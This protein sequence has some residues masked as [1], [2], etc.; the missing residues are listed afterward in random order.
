MSNERLAVLLSRQLAGE[1]SA[2]EQQELQYLLQ[3]DPGEQY[4][5]ELLLAYWNTHPG[6]PA[7][8][9][10]FR[11]QHF[12]HILDLAK[13][14]GAA[15][16]LR[17]DP[18]TPKRG[19][20]LRFRKLAV[21]ALVTGITAGGIGWYFSVKPGKEAAAAIKQNEIAAEK[22][23]KTQLVLPDGT[24]VWLNSDSRLTYDARFDDAVRE[25]TLEGEGYFDVV[26]NPRRPFIVHTSGID[27]RVLGTAFNVKS[28]PQEA[29]IEA[30]LIHGSIEVL[31]KK[32]PKAPKVI[33]RPHEK[34]VFN[35]EDHAFVTTGRPVAPLQSKPTTPKPAIAITSLPK[36]IPDTAVIETSWVYN[37]LLFDGDTFRE[38]AVKM[39]RWFNV[40]ISF[41]NEKV[42]NYRLRGVFENENIGEALQALQF[43]ASFSYKI[44]GN[45]VEISKK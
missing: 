13:S 22:G 6:Q 10:T 44:K 27:V 34:L 28:Y 42:A 40:R 39:E 19:I 36:N 8:N 21:A 4:L 20:L 38:L 24:K 37:K 29:T 3:E 2:A 9:P 32:E 14:N 33:L 41:K 43:I 45:E 17:E 23:A 12:A 26:K 7:G 1:A 15:P 31:N 30:T 18:V 25:V 5:A 35:K 11:D 16:A